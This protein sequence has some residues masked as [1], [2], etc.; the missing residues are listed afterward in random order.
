MAIKK[1]IQND[2]TVQYFLH[3]VENMLLTARAFIPQFK[4][5]IHAFTRK[6]KKKTYNI[7]IELLT[8]M[9]LGYFVIQRINLCMLYKMDKIYKNV[10][11]NVMQG[12]NTS[13]VVAQLV[14]SH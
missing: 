1:L 14:H 11:S 10:L 13:Y 2:N 12:T 4:L 6:Q 8:C 3:N 7:N 5:Y 9:A